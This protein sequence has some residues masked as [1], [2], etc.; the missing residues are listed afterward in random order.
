MQQAVSVGPQPHIRVGRVSGDLIV[1]SGKSQRVVIETDGV[2]SGGPSCEAEGRLMVG[3]CHGDLE[4]FLPADATLQVDWL[5]G[6]GRVQG[7]RRCELGKARSDLVVERIAEALVVGHLE[8]DL[9]VR[10]V[11][12]VRVRDGI[13]GEGLVKDVEQLE[14]ASLGGDLVVEGAGAVLIGSV[15]GD[16]R[17][18]AVATSLRCGRVEGDALVQGGKDTGVVL[19]MVQGDLELVG[20]ARVQVGN[21]EGDVMLR[22]ISG[23]IEIGQIGGDLDGRELAG[24]LKISQVLTDAVL[25]RVRASLEIGSV[26][27]SLS[28]QADFPEGS[29]TRL[30]VNED[31]VL[32]L[33]AQANLTLRAVVGGEV[34]GLDLGQGLEKGRLL[35]LV[36]GSGA[37]Q[38]ELYVGGDL[39]LQGESYPHVT[40]GVFRPFLWTWEDFESEMRAFGQTMANLGQEL[41][42]DVK[43]LAQD[44]ARELAET[45]EEYGA[46]WSDEV[47]RILEEQTR[48][49]RERT[50]SW[51]RRFA[52]I[53][54]RGG[55]PRVRLRF[56][57]HEWQMDPE[58]LYRML[59]QAQ[60]ATAEG[61]VGAIEAVERALRNLGLS[62]AAQTRRQTSSMAP[63]ESGP[64]K[65]AAAAASLANAASS[66][67]TDQR[68]DE[69]QVQPQVAAEPAAQSPSSERERE[70]ILRM[71]AEGR[72]SPEEGDMLLEALDD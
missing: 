5:A 46:H 21:V 24:H 36:Y 69:E 1:R 26:E 67:S 45:G 6:D 62:S 16:L 38:V 20:A 19:G 33:P 44:L 30:N 56:Q 28:L 55:G 3:D 63:G 17:L 57:E 2:L 23:E 61:V 43:R 9:E 34:S 25:K 54:P 53:W 27:G 66:A 42:H 18:P 22:D 52:R 15:G 4:L 71:V 39:R 65:A 58:R 48:R 32:T 11:P 31:V 41:A 68:T 64:E 47:L 12:L 7:I 29:S 60:R 49:A 13:G 37:A 14:I 70:A 40:E 10:G 72:L 51:E 50:A 35:S 59:D 8:G